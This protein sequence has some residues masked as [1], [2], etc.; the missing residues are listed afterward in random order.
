M[1]ELDIDAKY[2]TVHNDD[3]I[4]VFDVTLPGHPRYAMMQL[5]GHDGTEMD[6][7]GEYIEIDTTSDAF[8]PNTV[9]NASDYLLRYQQESS[10][11]SDLTPA[12]MLNDLPQLDVAALASVW[13]HGKFRARKDASGSDIAGKQETLA[14]P[15]ESL[16]AASMRAVIERTV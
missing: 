2:D 5:D 8:K 10:G 9:L 14:N 6:A 1:A 11:T 3:G 13:P 7:N 4:S 12:R 15:V 16:T